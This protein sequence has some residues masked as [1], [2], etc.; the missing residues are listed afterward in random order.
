[1]KFLRIA[2]AWLALC[3]AAYAQAQL[4]AGQVLGNS[5]AAQR[6][7]RAESVTAILDR[8]LSSTRGS[9]IER[10]ASGWAPIPPGTAGLPFVSAGAGADPLYQALGATGGGTGQTVYAIGDLLTANTT[11]TLQRLADVA[12]GNALISGGV[13]VV[14]SWGKITSSHLNITTTTCTNQFMTAL[15]ST[16]VGTCTTD[17]L[18]SAQHANQGTT[19]TVLHGNGAGNPSWGAVVSADMNITTTS[20][21]NQLISA[22]SSGGVGTCRSVAFADIASASV[23][24]KSDM[25]TPSSSAL[26]VTPA[27]VQNH[28]GVAKFWARL[29]GKTG[30]TCTIAASYNIASC[31]RNSAGSYTITFTTAFANANWAFIGGGYNSGTALA[32]VVIASSGGYTTTTA[33]FNCLT[34]GAA[35]Q[36]CDLMNVAGY[37]LQ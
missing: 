13:G 1:M 22:I 14:P 2:L 18:A 29:D 35:A 36:D 28:P 30:S 23:A 20:C 4:G 9:I 26:I 33:N 7:A 34:T 3:G 8:A 16:G 27:R 11:T 24:A 25:E 5:T 37:G 21:T 6:P 32:F 12:T 17:T 10:G 31:V 19:T 15:S